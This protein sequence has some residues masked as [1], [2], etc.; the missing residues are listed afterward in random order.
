M[1]TRII[2]NFISQNNN[3]NNNMSLGYTKGMP[4]RM[5]LRQVSS[6]GDFSSFH[7]TRYRYIFLINEDSK[8]MW[9]MCGFIG[10]IIY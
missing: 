8:Y 7:T 6:F 3:N 9:G 2:P 1:I 4:L 5:K 10:Y